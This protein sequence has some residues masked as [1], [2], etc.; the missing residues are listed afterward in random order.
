MYSWSR[1][2]GLVIAAV[3]TC[4]SCQAFAQPASPAKASLR[5]DWKG[6]GQHAPFYLAKE[7]GYYKDEGIDLDIISGSGSSDVAKQ[8]GSKAVEFGVADA[9]VLVQAAEQRVPLTAIAAYYQRTPIVVLSPRSKPVTDPRQL[10][11]GV[12]LGSKKGSATFQGLTAFLAANDIPM[13]NVT[14]VDIGFGVQPLLVKQVDA[15]MGFSMNEPIEAD[16]AGLPVTTMA[17]ADHGVDA[18]GLMIVSNSDVIAKN[19]ALVKGFLTAT[20]RGLAAATKDP[21]AAVAAVTNAISESDAAREAK[22]LDRTL[23]Y[24][25][26]DDKGANGVGWQSEGRW[27]HTITIARKLGLIDHDLPARQ[28]FSNDMLPH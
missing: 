28:L 5:L 27:E 17:I 25:Q 22:V 20:V 19:P 11:R 18:Y 12:R 13:E 1:R 10:T 21:A 4:G 26:S 3:L 7:R 16:S 24:F 2:L 14:L 8:V 6:G 23:P 9:L 15:M